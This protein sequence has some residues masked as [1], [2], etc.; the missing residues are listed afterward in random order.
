M[1]LRRRSLNL[2]SLPPKKRKFFLQRYIEF[3]EALPLYHTLDNKKLI[4]AHA[5]I[6]EN[7]LQS[8]NRKKIRSF[9]LYGDTTGE[10]H[11]NGRPV[12]KDWAKHYHGQSFIVYGHTP[13]TDARFIHNTVNI[14]TGCVF[15]GQLTAIRYPG[16]KSCLFNLLCHL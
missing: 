13:V 5:G 6:R 2:I 10:I 8:T 9:V 11:P 16:K 12:R 4:V 7:L 1:G 15:G 14:D 3:Y